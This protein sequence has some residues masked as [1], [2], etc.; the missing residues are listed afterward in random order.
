M[1]KLVEYKKVSEEE[2]TNDLKSLTKKQSA[3]NRLTENEGLI[4]MIEKVR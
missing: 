4:Y 1:W 2:P 3:M